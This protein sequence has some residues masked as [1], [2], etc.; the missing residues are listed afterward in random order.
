[1]KVA[2][3]GP[4]GTYTHQAVNQQF[5]SGNDVEILA[6]KSISDCF[7]ILNDEKVDYAVVPLEN[8][9][10]GQVVYTYDLLRDWFLFHDSGS[11]GEAADKP[12]FRV[13]AEQFVSIQHNFLTKAEKIEDVSVIYSH[14]QVWGQ[15]KDFFKN[16]VP[17]DVSTVDTGSTAKAAEKVYND[18]TKSSAC[19]SSFMSAQLYDLPILYKNIEDNSK[20]TTRFLVLGHK[21][22]SYKH[23]KPQ[24]DQGDR[25][26]DYVTLVTFILGDDDP[27]A[28]CDALNAFKTY[29]IN[30]TSINSRPY[31]GANWRYAF[32]IELIGNKD[33]ENV[34]KSLSDL[35]KSVSSMMV[36]GSFERCW[37]YWG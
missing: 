35:E 25:G 15:V 32:F 34:S 33:D 16:R 31:P 5:G 37:R 18:E 17:K 2:F 4:E 3:L 26:Q 6:Q 11:K 14:P 28:L 24:G 23:D 9:T 27:G 22:I 29:N 13:V 19:I 21:G 7:E 10:N 36:L 8:S 1:M 12:K 20:N 30:L